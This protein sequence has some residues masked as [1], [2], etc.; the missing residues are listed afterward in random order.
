MI[1]KIKKSSLAEKKVNQ[2]FL[3]TNKFDLIMNPEI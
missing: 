3:Y 2:M 1:L